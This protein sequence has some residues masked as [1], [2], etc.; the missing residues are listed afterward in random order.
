MASEH[1]SGRRKALLVA[2]AA[3]LAALGLLPSR[4][5]ASSFPRLDKA[6]VEMREARKFL[7]NAPNKFGGHKKNA[8]E[9]LTT[10][11]NEIEAAIKFAGG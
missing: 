8:I 2:G 5:R 11:I 4:A 10:A 7:Q 9:A 3:S 6:L 1:S